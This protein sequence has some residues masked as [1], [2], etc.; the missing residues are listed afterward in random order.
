MR[1]LVPHSSSECAAPS[2]RRSP[3][4]SRGPGR[5]S[6][7]HLDLRLH[8]SPLGDQASRVGPVSP[9]G[10]LREGTRTSARS[11]VAGVEQARPGAALATARR[12]SPAS[13]SSCTPGRRSATMWVRSIGIAGRRAL[14]AQLPP[15]QLAEVAPD[16]LGRHRKS[17]GRA[18]LTST[19]P[20]R[21][22]V[23]QDSCWRSRRTGWRRRTGPLAPVR[24]CDPSLMTISSGPRQT[25][26][27]FGHVEAHF[28][29]RVLDVFLVD[30]DHGI[31][32]SFG[33]CF[34][35]T[36]V[37]RH[38]HVFSG[39]L[40]GL[41]LYSSGRFRRFTTRLDQVRRRRS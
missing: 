27:G 19:R 10:P 37:E 29:A 13:L 31:S 35:S 18:P 6:I 8:H 33:T 7:N 16:R 1:G 32:V 36:R 21:R 11:V 17:G 26:R 2:F 20:S 15:V 4:S 12:I 28:D 5:P 40:V 22:A 9:R 3:A 39:L 25:R 14:A 38:F 34:P 24:A 30:F 23:R 41:W